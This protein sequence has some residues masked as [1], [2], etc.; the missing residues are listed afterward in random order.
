MTPQEFMQPEVFS[1]IATHGLR[2]S[3]VAVLCP[4]RIDRGG[5]PK[6]RLALSVQSRIAPGTVALGVPERKKSQSTKAIEIRLV[7]A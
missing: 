7:F 4:L 6:E 2:L 3:R 1:R 5:L